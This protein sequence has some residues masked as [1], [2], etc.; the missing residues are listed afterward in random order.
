LGRVD[1]AMKYAQA[2]GVQ[3]NIAESLR[4]MIDINPEGALQYAKSL[5]QK[6]KNLNVQQLADLFL[7]RNRIQ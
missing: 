5:Y 1:E 6:D 7:Q 2:N 4:S 3:I